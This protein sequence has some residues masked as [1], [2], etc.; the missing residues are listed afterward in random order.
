[1]LRQTSLGVVGL[2]VGGILTIIGFIAYFILDN[3]TLNLVGFFYG[4]PILL[5]GLAL[6]AAELEPTPYSEPPSTEIVALR[7]R[8]STTTQ[9]QIRKDVTR[10]RYGQRVHLD[11]SLQALGLSPT[12]EECPILK[13][14]REEDIDGAYTLVLQ[15]E[16]PFFPASDWKDKEQKMTGFFGPGVQVKVTALDEELVDVAIIATPQASEI[17]AAA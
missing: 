10:F 4:I 11:T 3:A 17:S 6:K 16:S 7:D 15:F 5:G 13:N 9:T 14:I 1:M 2:V 8:Q 12:D